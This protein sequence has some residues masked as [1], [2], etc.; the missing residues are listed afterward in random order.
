MP[1]LH[2]FQNVISYRPFSVEVRMCIFVYKLRYWV[3]HDLMAV[4]VFHEII[5][6]AN[7]SHICHMNLGPVRRGSGGW[8]F[9]VHK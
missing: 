8:V 3:F 6:K 5:P 2:V 4:S 1:K 9:E 7:P